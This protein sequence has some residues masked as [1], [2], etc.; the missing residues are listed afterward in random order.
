MKIRLSERLVVK[1]K[2]INS[3]NPKL[4]RAI[5]KQLNLCQT[6]PR[7]KS[8]RIH[9]LSG[10]MKDIWSISISRNIR[11]VYIKRGDEAYF[12]DVG[13]HDQVYKK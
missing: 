6:D 8:L 11:M 1:I 3:K 9:K 5:K 4:A 7:H 12:F 13:T 2:K 10:E